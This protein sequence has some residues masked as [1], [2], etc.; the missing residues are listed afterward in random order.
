MAGFVTA[1]IRSN[2]LTDADRP[3]PRLGGGR[4]DV[5]GCCSASSSMSIA[6][7]LQTVLLVVTFNSPPHPVTLR[8]TSFFLR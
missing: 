3:V 4:R 7:A 6:A 1:L 5:L 8:F 2:W